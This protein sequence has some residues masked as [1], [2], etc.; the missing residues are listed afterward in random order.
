MEF[1]VLGPVEV[2][3][4]GVPGRIGSATQRTLLAILLSHPNEVVSTD[5]IIEVL[6]PDDPLDGRRKLWFHVSKLRAI[7]EPDASDERAGGRLAARPHGYLLRVGGDELDSTRFEALTAAARTLLGADPAQAAETLRTAL[8]LWRG[9]PFADVVHEYAV[10]AAAARLNEVRIAALED[11]LAADLAT[12]LGSELIPE[13]EALVAQHPYREH[14]HGQLM[15]ALYRAGRQADA[16]A[17]YL[18]A[19]RMLV[20]EL[21]IEPS[22][23]LQELQRQ[24]LAHDPALVGSRVLLGPRSHPPPT[25]GPGPPLVTD[26]PEPREERKVITVLYADLVDFT[27]TAEQL[28]P[29]DVRALVM[30]YYS[31]IRDELERVG[32]RVEKFIGD[33]VVA[34]FGA[35]VA[36]EDD[37]ERAVRAA[38][39]IRDWLAGQAGPQGARIAVA[40][41]PAH[42]RLGALEAE[43]EPVAVGDVVN[44]AARMQSVAPVNGVLVGERTYRATRHVIEYRDAP[45]IA[46]RGK[47][48]PI[49]AW[50]ASRPLALP[51]IDLLR[52][53]SPFVGRHLELSVLRERFAWAASQ[54]SPQLVTIIGVPG[55]GKTRLLSEVQ[56]AAARADEPLKWRQGRSLPYGDG[57]SF[58]A[59]GE[60]VKAEAGILESDSSEQ[61]E[62]KLRRSVQQIVDDA[63]EARRFASS[64]GLL[65]GVDGG[66]TAGGD[67]RAERFGAWRDFLE[68]VAAER[69]LVLVFEDL[70]WADDGL[71]DFVDELV[72]RVSGVPLLVVVTAR[73]E[74][75]RRRPGWAGGK[76]NAVTL[77]LPPLSD[78]DTAR[79]VAALLEETTG[80]AEI[81]RAILARVGGNPLFAEQFCRMLLET[82][83]LGELP[84]TVQGIIAARLDGLA[85]EQKALLQRAAVVGK[86]FWTGAVEVLEGVS[87]QRADELLADLEHMEFLYRAR[88]SSV[89]GSTQYA[90][91]HDLLL[92]VAYAGIPRSGRGELHR[93]TAEWID[94]L[95]HPDD[96]AELL[97]HHYLAAFE[98]AAAGGQDVRSLVEPTIRALRRAGQRTIQLSANDRAVEYLTRAIELVH[99]LEAGDD[100]NRTEAELQVQLGVALFAL[101][102]H[103]APEVERAYARAADLMLASA[104]AADQFP[105]QF[106]LFILVTQ[107][108]NFAQSNPLIER[109]AGLARDDDSLRMEALHCRWMNSLFSGR[110]DDTVATAEEARRMYRPDVHHQLT[111]RYA[112]HDPGVCALSQQAVALALRGDSAMAQ[113]RI[114]EAIALSEALGH[115]V[116]RVQPLCYL[117]WISQINGWPDAALVEADAALALE[118]EVV[119]PLWFGQARAARGWA[120]SCI[121]RDSEG[122]GELERVLAIHLGMA[123]QITAVLDAALLAEAHLR[124]GRLDAARAVAREMRP[125]ADA[126]R[127]YTFEP[128]LLRVEAQCSHLEG[129]DADARRLYLRAIEMARSQGSWALATRS[130]VQLARTSPTEHEP[131]FVL[132][133]DLR[134]H[135]PPDNDT[136][137]GREADALLG[138]IARA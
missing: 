70:H 101:R 29:E 20:D 121:G 115:A 65:L 126:M 61:V 49:R 50:E 27:A 66:A 44:T 85:P 36:H 108:G 23:E 18:H 7:L 125:N 132:L 38:L 106:G 59:L 87:R 19:R 74:L 82:G 47:S 17:A 53:R 24:V 15:V 64:L 107:R 118:G 86:V 123:C 103:T 93:L 137:Y 21:G 69:L 3:V 99:E 25:A 120:L 96:H 16:L 14:F 73:P 48:H 22:D 2:L 31:H 98:Y 100:R 102:G 113:E 41:G 55:I 135:L 111:F 28:D 78:G 57:V 105:V 71:L 12:G 33:A 104:P 46:V 9:E 130:A 84:E 83:E 40:T 133:R 56:Q 91:R 90:F 89:A 51:G 80:D 75:L 94:S 11:R 34:I 131:N 10:S 95:G 26:A 134:E 112:N 39:A 6:W 1:R 122:V 81:R 60:I 5:R 114:R 72:D 117:P 67:G 35:A 32:G 88:R 8:A 42:V 58:W 136:D 68:T 43:G 128:D 62:L 63:G 116:S 30:P 119:H 138:R 97:A 109:M 4:D 79:L 13:L 76:P 37:P 129:S 77:T 45:L 110:V 54:R 124:G 52:H 92:D 127:T